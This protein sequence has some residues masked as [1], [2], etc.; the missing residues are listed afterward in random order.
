MGIAGNFSTIHSHTTRGYS[1]LKAGK[2]EF[3]IDYIVCHFIE[4]TRH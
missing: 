2:N 1:I 3:I 4:E